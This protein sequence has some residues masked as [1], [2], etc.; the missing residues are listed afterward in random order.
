MA[1]VTLTYDL[2]EEESEYKLTTKAVDLSLAI[3]DFTH[4]L[5]EKIKYQQ[6]KNTTWDDVSKTW[7]TILEDHR[8]DPYED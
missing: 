8:I 5:R 6:I 7:W 4:L 2:P 3:S 1:K